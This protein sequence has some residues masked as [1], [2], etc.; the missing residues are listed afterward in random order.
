M[1]QRRSADSRQIIA[2]R[3]LHGHFAGNLDK[4]WI[5]DHG[6]QPIVPAMARNHLGSHGSIDS[7]KR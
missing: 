1:V 5:N 7:F 4:P 2:A 6:T 3:S